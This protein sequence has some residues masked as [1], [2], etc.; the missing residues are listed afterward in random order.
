MK[1]L[2]VLIL[3]VV[4]FGGAA[5]FA[6]DL[7]VKPE[8]QIKAEQTGEA[9]TPPAADVSGPEFQQAA[10]LRQEGKLAECRDA[11]ALF[12]QKYPAGQHTEQAKDLLG[13]VN[14]QILLS[15]YPS[16]EKQEYI[17]KS[18]DVINRVAQK[19]KT[20]PELIM[21]LNSLDSTMLRIG[22]RLWIAHPDFA[23]FIQRRPQD[24]VLLNH[25]GFFK[26]YKITA[27]KLPAKQPPRI[28]TKVAEVMAWRFGKRVGLGSR[29]YRAAIHWIRLVQPGYTLFAD[30]PTNDV[31][32]PP[33]G[34]GMNA[35]DLDELSSL[36]NKNTAVTITD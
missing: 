34:L 16:P 13:D 18:G 22:E 20:T 28:N 9:P 6:Y 4:I 36:V 2:F 7:F 31:A 3:A 19:T 29:E 33:I 8:K 1:W 10:Q 11:L 23:L 21:R 5:F 26:R 24:V 32:P 15:D 25:G 30:P 17:V 12:L 14:M 35:N 27:V